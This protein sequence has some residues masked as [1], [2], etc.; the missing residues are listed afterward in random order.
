[1]LTQKNKRADVPVRVLHII[2]GKHFGG[3]EQV[4]LTLTTCSN[5]LSVSPSVLSLSA[6]LLLEKLAEAGIRNFLVP[7]ESKQ[8]IFSPLVKTI[9]LIRAER[10]EVIHTHTVRSNLIGRLA[11]LFT[12]RPCV[13]HLH[14]P[15]RRDFANFNRGRRN[16]IIDS[17]TRPIAKR[18]I[19]VSLSL[20]REMIEHGFPS[21]KI[22]TI[23]NALD[24]NSFRSLLVKADDGG[25]RQE[26][27]IPPGSFVLVL[28][29]LLRPRKG[30]EVIIRAM[31]SILTYSPDTY[32]LIVGNDDI[33]EDPEYG[34]RLRTLTANLG[35]ESNVIF[36]GFRSD[37]LAILSKCDLMILPSLFGEGLPM[38]ILEA[39][40]MG[41]PVIASKVEGI[42]EVIDDGVNGFLVKPGDSEQL[43]E[44]I[45]S[46]MGDP[47]LLREVSQKGRRKV[48][49]EMNGYSQALQ[50]EH[51]YREIV[52]R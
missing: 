43:S 44:K 41:V 35:L 32:L 31:K 50:V 8:D 22:V 29:A 42:P 2:Q 17:L 26:Y 19:A 5:P 9:R 15:I 11:A 49:D 21:Q 20:R 48:M 45:V 47:I 23:H 3:A 13:T 37:V 40:A 33:S 52:K 25:I 12:A 46:I 7:M 10:I 39:M 1:V 6:G 51:V 14:S 28:V 24:P 18:Y 30:V 36:T 34:K 16:E 27:G 4:V 38:V